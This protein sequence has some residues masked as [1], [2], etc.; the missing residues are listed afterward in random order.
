MNH[1]V[2]PLF[3][4]LSAFLKEDS[5]AA[6]LSPTPL[7]VMLRGKEFQALLYHPSPHDSG[8]PFLIFSSGDGGWRDFEQKNGEWLSQNGSWVLGID[9][10]KYIERPLSE[11]NIIEDYRQ[12]FAVFRNSVPNNK[13]RPIILI[14]YSFGAELI[15]PLLTHLTPDDRIAGLAL[16][17][18]G[19]R[20]SF[21]IR[22]AESSGSDISFL[23][24]D[25]LPKLAGLPIFFLHGELDRIGATPKLYES[26]KEPK[27]LS[28]IKGTGHLFSSGT[29]GY[30]NSLQEG[31]SWIEELN[32]PVK[33]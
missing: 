7:S 26:S 18:P 31:I 6:T 16:I 14:G 33:R 22:L 24:A 10:V 20:G 15:V 29:Q 17:S 2:F 5:Y 28:I 13:D 32:S 11:E 19:E 4:V 25:Y 21:K 30:F 23:L 27:R 3:L 1:R 8:H 9:M 12:F